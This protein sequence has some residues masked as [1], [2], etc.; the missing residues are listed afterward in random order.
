ML[1]IGSVDISS[2]IGNPEKLTSV[3]DAAASI[4]PESL[5]Q[6]LGNALNSASAEAAGSSSSSALSSAQSIAGGQSPSFSSV[7][8]NAVQEINSK[9]TAADV[10]KGKLLTGETSNVHQAMIAVQ[11]SS[12]AFSLMVEVRNKLVDSYQ[13]LMR[14]QV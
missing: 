5:T 2:Y 13:E 9:M 10:E 11:E 6:T 1:P 12:V 4:D 14:T 7:L 3:K 8:Q